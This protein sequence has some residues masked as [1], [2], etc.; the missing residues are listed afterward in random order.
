MKTLTSLCVSLSYTVSEKNQ[1]LVVK[2]NG[3]Q[4]ILEICTNMEN[5]NKLKSEAYYCLSMICL[6]NSYVY[7]ELSKLIETDQLIR[8]IMSLLKATSY[9]L[10]AKVIEKDKNQSF[11][12]KVVN[13]IDDSYI[14]S[15]QVIDTLKCQLKSGL[16]LCSFSFQ[17]DEFFRNIVTAVG[18]IDWRIFKNIIELLNAKLKKSVSEKNSEEYFEIQKMRCIL[19]YQITILHNLIINTDED[20]RAV[21][22]K[23]MID[24]IPYSTNTALRSISCD[25]LGRTVKFNVT[26]IESLLCVNSIEL[27]ANSTLEKNVDDVNLN[28]GNTEK[29]VAAL[30][31]G[32]LT[33][34]NP[35]ARRRLLKVARRFPKIMSELKQ[36]NEILHLD[37][38]N[39]WKHFM[40][41]RDLVENDFSL[42]DRS[43]NK[44]KTANSFVSNSID[45]NKKAN[46]KFFQNVLV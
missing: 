40:E 46:K 13:K 29:G 11:K 10:D 6:K 41:L 39:E 7:Q 5:S 2:L 16:T 23:M 38:L 3:L 28:V 15:K 37:L 8:N 34:L 25:Y 31:L 18:K 20:P 19:G 24:I 35:E 1:N 33:S 4:V 14:D 32:L 44:F 17:N 9:V 21:G 30:T 42:S 36:T 12:N 43:V 45:S 26:L 22:I 27:L